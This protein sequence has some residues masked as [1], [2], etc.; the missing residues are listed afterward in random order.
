MKN[1]IFKETRLIFQN[2]GSPDDQPQQS[3]ERI[4]PERELIEDKVSKEVKVE[5]PNK[6]KS[7]IQD[8]IG[9]LKQ[10]L[11]EVLKNDKK[12]TEGFVSVAKEKLEEINNIENTLMGQEPITEKEKTSFLKEFGKKLEPHEEIIPEKF[13]KEKLEYYKKAKK[14]ID[15][16]R[17]YIKN[18]REMVENS[19]LKKKILDILVERGIRDEKLQ[20]QVLKKIPAFHGKIVEKLKTADERLNNLEKIEDDTPDQGKIIERLTNIN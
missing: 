20:K 11:N 7:L 9:E 16:K 5:S 19:S 4:V 8:Q 3:S 17:G 14:E 10:A 12:Y 13:S 1:K 18:S 2:T 15:K 6:L